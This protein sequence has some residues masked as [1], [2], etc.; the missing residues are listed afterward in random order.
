MNFRNFLLESNFYNKGTLNLLK[1]FKEKNNEELYI[2]FSDEPKLSKKKIFSDFDIYGLIGYNIDDIIKKLKNKEVL[3]INSWAIKKYI[4][5][6]K[7]FRGKIL[8]IHDYN[9]NKKLAEDIITLKKLFYKLY[10]KNDIDEIWKNIIHQSQKKFEKNWFKQLMSIVKSMSLIL[11]INAN[12]ILR[13]LKYSAI[14]AD[15]SDD[16]FKSSNPEFFY[17]S[18]KNIKIIEIL[19]NI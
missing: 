3:G 15:N 1:Q 17:L 16:S 14:K 4:I 19:D 12:Q 13:E 10:Q 18:I 5:V 6:T 2:I 11:N 7:L 8:N 9:K